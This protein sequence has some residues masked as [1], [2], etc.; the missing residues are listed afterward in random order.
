MNRTPG[1]RKLDRSR[2][3]KRKP[4]VT[5]GN[6]SVGRAKYLQ[7]ELTDRGVH[8]KASVIDFAVLGPAHC[9]SATEKNLQ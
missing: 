1:P 3:V 7:A 8:Q 2:K 6:R 5:T 4:L 9:A